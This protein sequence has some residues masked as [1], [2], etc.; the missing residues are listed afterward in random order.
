MRLIAIILAAVILVS[1]ASDDPGSQAESS[2]DN[3]SSRITPSV[4]SEPQD[5]QPDNS[6]PD[7]SDVILAPRSNTKIEVFDNSGKRIGELENNGCVTLCNR[8]IVYCS[9]ADN[10]DDL[11][12]EFNLFDAKTGKTTRLGWIEG[13]IFENVFNRI[14]IGDHV[15]TLVIKGNLYDDE[16]DPVYLVDIDLNGLVATHTITDDGFAYM[17]MCEHNGKLLI[18]LHDQQDKTL[19]DRIFEYD[20]STGKKREVITAELDDGEK[21]NTFRQIWSDGKNVYVLRIAMNGLSD[22]KM[23]LD[24]YDA[25]YNKISEKDITGLFLAAN[26]DRS[27]ED[28]SSEMRQP[29]AYFRVYDGRYIYYENFSVS[30]FFADLE[31]GEHLIETNGVFSAS[32]GSG[33]TFWFWSFGGR[34]AGDELSL[35]GVFELHD[36]KLEKSLYTDPTDSRY[37]IWSA[38]SSAD[39]TRMYHCGY[40]DPDTG[41]LLPSKLTVVGK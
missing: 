2:K 7:N 38:C 8:G 5:S 20:P 31:T 30:R 17:S 27:P 39:G 12:N 36:G 23:M 34:E 37:E 9:A 3:D 21:G 29:V 40:K 16:P 10:G 13:E 14:E 32:N 18:R 15:Y 1:C 24:I 4:P 19:F 11:K 6:Q 33:K 25:E 26:K 41:E 22:V 35:N 28:I